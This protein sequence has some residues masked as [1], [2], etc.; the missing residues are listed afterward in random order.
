MFYA[1]Y[2]NRERE[3]EIEIDGWMISV[4][5]MPILLSVRT[6][7]ASIACVHIMSGNTHVEYM[8]LIRLLHLAP[9]SKRSLLEKRTARKP[10]K[11][12][13]PRHVRNFYQPEKEFE[14]LR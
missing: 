13:K 6:Y 4:K 11:T 2:P 3:R 14:Q 10:S 1:H 8:R 12:P 5:Q 7:K 9:S